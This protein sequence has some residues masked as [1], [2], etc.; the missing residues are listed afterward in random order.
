MTAEGDARSA[1]G[2]LRLPEALLSKPTDASETSGVEAL[3][4]ATKIRR[5]S[6]GRTRPGR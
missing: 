2:R 6:H 4:L 3:Y 5:M 1:R